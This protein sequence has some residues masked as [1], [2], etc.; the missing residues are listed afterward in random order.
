MSESINEIFNRIMN[1]TVS[2]EEVDAAHA[3]VVKSSKEVRETF[4]AMDKR[5]REIKEKLR[6]GRHLTADEITRAYNM[7][8]ASIYADH[9]KGFSLD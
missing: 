6:F 2:R 4:D 8:N 3:R 5:D 9:D 1:G 7:G